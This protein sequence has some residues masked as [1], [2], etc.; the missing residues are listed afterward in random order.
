V[1]IQII[2][3]F[4]NHAEKVQGTFTLHDFIIIIFKLNLKIKFIKSLSR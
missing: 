3:I 2:L 1:Y 4:I